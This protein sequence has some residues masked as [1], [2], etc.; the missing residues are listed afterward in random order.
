M[1]AGSPA[2][3]SA[4]VNASLSASVLCQASHPARGGPSATRAL[5]VAESPNFP[6]SAL[7]VI[8]AV[9]P[10]CSTRYVTSRSVSM[11]MQGIGIAPDLEAGG[12][13]DLPL[14]D[15]GQHHDDPVA[16][17]HP[18]RRE[19]VRDPVAG[20]RHVVECQP[21]FVALRIAPDEGESRRIPRP[22]V[23][24]LRAEI[25][26]GRRL[27]TVPRYR[28]LVVVHA[29]GGCLGGSAHRSPSSTRERRVWCEDD[30]AAGRPG[31]ERALPLPRGLHA[32]TG[33]QGALTRVDGPTPSGTG[34]RTSRP[35]ALVESTWDYEESPTGPNTNRPKR[36]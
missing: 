14:G 19:T 3:T 29:I 9:A 2:A 35:S 23:D 13:R 33:R 30:R 12:E 32:T 26:G 31:Q 5:S 7:V 17:A 4:A 24:D 11:V 16:L 15:P 22:R 36:M 10:E 20:T 1:I 21:A 34:R 28:T 8:A 6:V 25:E 27:E 18:A